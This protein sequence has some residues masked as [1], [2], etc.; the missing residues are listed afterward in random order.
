MKKYRVTLTRTYDIFISAN[1]KEDA[2]FFVE[3]YLD[4]CKDISTK[5]DKF[6][7]NFNMTMI[8]PT[9]NEATEITEG[10]DEK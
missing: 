9:M 7:K 3:Y 8:K 2:K 5:K 10:Y 4:D 1:N 6:E